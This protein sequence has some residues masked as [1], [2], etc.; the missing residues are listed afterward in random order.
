MA[1]KDVATGTRLRVRLVGITAAL[2]LT[3]AATLDTGDFLRFA[4]L[5]L[6]AF[7]LSAAL[8]LV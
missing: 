2:A 5:A 4:V 6:G 8:A 7:L 3:M 1:D